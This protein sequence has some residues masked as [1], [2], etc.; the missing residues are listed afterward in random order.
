V[1]SIQVIGTTGH[2][3]K[4]YGRKERTALLKAWAAGASA[5]V[6]NKLCSGTSSERMPEGECWG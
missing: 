2:S 3:N 4:S 5:R 1:P 6:G